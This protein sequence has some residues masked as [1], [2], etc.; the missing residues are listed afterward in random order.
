MDN[1]L[2]AMLKTGAVPP[3]Q[4][5]TVASPAGAT[6]SPPGF[7]PVSLD[8]LFKSINGPP[9]PVGAAGA[10]VAAAAAVAPAA[11]VS[12]SSP[13]PAAPPPNQNAAQLLGM[14]GGASATPDT[15]R[16]SSDLDSKD[17]R[18]SSLLNALKSCV[19]V[20]LY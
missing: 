3:A 13:S 8:D 4:P 11:A 1:P 20:S 15:T 5:G 16:P 7:T 17:R 2:L 6:P 10:A 18:R 12:A 19:C 9:K 14:L